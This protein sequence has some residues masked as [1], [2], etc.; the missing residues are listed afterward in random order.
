MSSRR[1]TLL[2]RVALVGALV[3]L[4]AT[5]CSTPAPVTDYYVQSAPNTLTPDSLRNSIQVAPARPLQ[6]TGKVLSAANTLYINRPYEGWHIIDNS[7]PSAPRNVGFITAPGSL[8]GIVI[9][10]DL[11]LENSIDLVVLSISNGTNPTLVRRLQNVL[12]IPTSPR[13]VAGAYPSGQIV[14]GWHDTTVSYTH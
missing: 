1:T 13:Q 9:G 5:A 12:P 10:S 8:D 14:V 3:A 6:K 7:T 11:Y 2:Y 4:V